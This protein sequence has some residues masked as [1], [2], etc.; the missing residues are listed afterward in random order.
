MKPRELHWATGLLQ[1]EERRAAL[2]GD[3]LEGARPRASL[4]E[5]IEQTDVIAFVTDQFVIG[6]TRKGETFIVC[7]TCRARS[8]NAHDVQQRYCGACHCFHEGRN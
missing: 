1:R 5:L 2:T 4:S 6:E 3:A 7:G 8:Y